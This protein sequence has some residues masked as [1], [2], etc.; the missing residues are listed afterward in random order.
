ME[1]RNVAIIAHVDH[2]KT[3][4][5]DAVLKQTGVF[6]PGQDVGE[7]ILDSNDLERERGITIL[8]K[9]TG[10][11]HRGAKIN[12]VDTP[13]HADF[14][15]EVERIMNMV[16]GALLIVDAAEG[17]LPQTR[18]V[19]DKALAAGVVPIVVV[20]KIDRPDAR[21]EEVLDEVLDLFIDLGADERQLDFP[22]FYASARLGI[23]APDLEQARRQM[24]GQEPG[25]VLGLLDCILE[26]VPAPGG[27]P[28]APFQLLVTNL[29]YDDY[30]GR[31]VIGRVQRGRVRLRDPLMRCRGGQPW[32]VPFEVSGLFTF[33]RLRRV[34]AGDAG[35]GEIVALAGLEDVNVGDTLCAPDHPEP[36]PPLEVDEPTLTVIFR[37]NDGPFAGREGRMVTARQ[38][39]ERLQKEAL[40]NVALRVGRTASPDAFEVSG[41]GELHLGILM[42]T[43]RRE[44]YEFSVSKPQVVWRTVDGVRQEPLERVTCDV[45]NEYVGAVMETLG[46]RKGDLVEMRRGMETVRLV[47]VVPARGLIG[48]AGEFVTLT[49]GYGVLHQNFEGYGP[50]RGEIPGRGTGS[51]VA[52]EDGEATAYAIANT[53]ERARLF[54]EPGTPVYAG[55]VVGENSRP[56]DLEVNIC[57]KKHVS[58]VRSSTA[59]IAVKI[60]PPRRLRL[61]EALAFIAEDELVELTP[62]S[63]RLRKAVLDR[64]ERRRRRVGD[65]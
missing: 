53:Q 52:M 8:A 48:F 1:I 13:G 54:I 37:V 64:G 36:L 60:D 15:G 38:L 7:R 51:V 42:E 43:M 16:D 5:V 10:V 14:G 62:R 34:P 9:Q 25:S 55:M 21:V 39:G 11:F 56:Q 41:R 20:N 6:R 57:K 22:V 58:N 17:P 32:Q 50:S 35:A 29:D 19:L 40:T 18:Y 26:H 28:E 24:G 23:A 4:L 2:G 30:I 47:Y 12:I 46:A 59:D 61:E 65:R 63:I 45:P 31:L 49:R 44:G 27:D 33:D 3:T